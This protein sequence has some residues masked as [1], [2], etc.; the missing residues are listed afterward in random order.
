MLRARM[1][2]ILLQQYLPKADIGQ[3]FDHLVGAAETVIGM[4]R[5]SGQMCAG[6][7]AGFSPTVA[8][9]H[10]A[11]VWDEFPKRIGGRNAISLG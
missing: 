8:V 1:L 2:K 10:E 9:A 3:L 4:L 5:P 6:Q 11:A 7:T